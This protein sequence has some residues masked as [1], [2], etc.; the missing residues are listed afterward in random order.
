[1]R[2]HQFPYLFL[3]YCLVW[4]GSSRLIILLIF[5]SKPYSFTSSCFLGREQKF[6]ILML[7]I[8]SSHQHSTGLDTTHIPWL[9]VGKDNYFFPL[10]VATKLFILYQKTQI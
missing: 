4:S 10:N 2:L 1:M 7:C 8:R 5:R 9:Q 3:F 6:N